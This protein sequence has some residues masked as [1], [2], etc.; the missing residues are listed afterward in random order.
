MLVPSRSD[1]HEFV[2]NR[3]VVLIHLTEGWKVPQMADHPDETP[4]QSNNQV[5]LV[6][7][8]DGNTLP[9]DASPTDLAALSRELTAEDI[10]LSTGHQYTEIDDRCPECDTKLEITRV[11]PDAE[12]GAHAPTRCSND[13]CEWAGTAVY[14]LIDLEKRAD[15]IP[16]SA[17][18]NGGAQPTYYPY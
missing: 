14:R 15:G 13:D 1:H 18:A 9:D 10:S 11:Q 4:V 5:R 8:I 17:V 3:V 6:L 7:T 2:T 12:N 16:E